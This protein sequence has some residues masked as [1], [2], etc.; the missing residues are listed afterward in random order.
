[1]VEPPSLGMFKN[2]LDVVLRD[3]IWWRVV[4]V[5]VVWLGEVGLDDLESL[6]QPK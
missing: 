2:H 3:V 6:F 4:R 5:R 1:V